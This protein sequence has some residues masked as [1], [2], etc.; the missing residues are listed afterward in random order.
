M[1]RKWFEFKGDLADIAVSSR[2]RLARNFREYPF[3]GRMAPEQEEQ[4]LDKC[5]KAM[6]ETSLLGQELTFYDGRTAGDTRLG[7]M[8]ESH[9]IS[10]EFASSN[11]I[12][13]VY[14][15]KDESV[16]IMVNEEDHVRLQVTGS[17]LCLEKCLETAG[18]LDDLLEESISFAWNEKYGYLTH[19]PTNL[20]TGLRAS[21]MLHL[22]AL[23][24]E[25][26]MNAIA[27]MA[28]KLGIT[29]RGFFGEG[30]SA[31]GALYQVSN[32]FTLGVTEKETIVRVR[33]MVEK[34]I[35]EEKAV[36]GRWL[37]EDRTGIE[38]K[39]FRAAALLSGARRMDTGEAMSLLS[40][41][42]LG[43]SEGIINTVEI[44]T[45]N[46]L[47]REIMP[48]TLT[49]SAGGSLS[50]QQR[51]ARRADILRAGLAK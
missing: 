44:D 22:P 33:D 18:K 1:I 39:V 21:V 41:L 32:Q 40:D 28:G 24:Q 35:H 13:G 48:A 16:S 30:S 11:H 20:G 27:G 10:P 25:G 31:L 8:V 3:P 49:M 29:I 42:R 19:C 46:R 7:S 50:Q 43:V 45:A 17:G 4:V 14:I 26:G 36:R 51:D 38:D 2:I 5:G 15:S 6:K 37:K 9:L 23:T 47:L 34:I 12:R